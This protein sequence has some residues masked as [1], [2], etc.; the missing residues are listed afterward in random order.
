MVPPSSDRITRVPPYLSHAQFY[1]SLFPY[2]A[3][4]RYGWPFHAILINELLKRAGFSD[5][6]RHY[7]RNLG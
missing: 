1:S 6:A 7:F 4:T 2:G 5:F 3:I